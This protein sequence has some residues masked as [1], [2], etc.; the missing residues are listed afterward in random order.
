MQIDKGILPVVEMMNATGWIETCG[1]CQG[2]SRGFHKLPYVLFDCRQNE[3]RQL[4]TILD[5]ADKE[6]EEIG[7]PFSIDCQLVFNTDIGSNTV[8]AYLGWV[9]FEIRP[10][11]IKGY[12]MLGADKEIFAYT[13]ANE[14]IDYL[15]QF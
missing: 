5:N 2:H 6:L 11:V 8:D 7:A 14:F 3:I 12:R 4:A 1:S 15:K 9:T 13:I 10:S